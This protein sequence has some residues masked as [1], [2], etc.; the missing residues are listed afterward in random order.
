MWTSKKFNQECNMGKREDYIKDTLLG[1]ETP[2]DIPSTWNDLEKLLDKPNKKK[3]PFWFYLI[4]ALS[5]AGIALSIYWVN[6]EQSPIA[7]IAEAVTEEV[8]VNKVE[9][10]EAMNAEVLTTSVD[11]N[12]SKEVTGISLGQETAEVLLKNT[13]EEETKASQSLQEQ[14]YLTSSQ[15]KVAKTIKPI[16]KGGLNNANTLQINP[17]IETRKKSDVL[18]NGNIKKQETPASSS[19]HLISK[20]Q[21]LPRVISRLK[22]LNVFD[23]KNQRSPN[24]AAL[25]MPLEE[26]VVPLRSSSGL[27][28]TVE[29]G[30]TKHSLL[31]GEEE[32]TDSQSVLADVRLSNNKTLGEEAE[33]EFIAGYN[34]GMALSYSLKNGITF[35]TGLHYNSFH[36]KLVGEY[37][38]TE[39]LLDTIPTIVFNNSEGL[40]VA[41]FSVTE[42]IARSP[43][44]LTHY[45]KINTLHVPLNVGY[46]FRRKGF[47]LI[48]TLG[49]G[50]NMIASAQGR[51]FIN[52]NS[53]ADIS[54]E[55]PYKQNAL[56]YSMQAELGIHKRLSN[57]FNIYAGVKAGKYL[58]DIGTEAFSNSNLKYASLNL[59][60]SHN[61]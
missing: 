24:I 12:K 22:S 14:K 9:I 7:V 23:T 28:L 39:D 17:T 26:S 20:L 5:L 4:G 8:A 50:I 44:S 41:D 33:L 57:D 32:L 27:L 30:L 55:Q 34:L 19:V 51:Y 59:G 11:L 29:G 10:Q 36:S 37:N 45:N 18:S 31:F 15:M 53:V 42:S 43:R 48:S 47:Q 13:I 21:L 25:H 58:S 60:I 16:S 46:N 1:Y 6:M 38:Q 52:A 49:I 35:G 3:R 2:V 56:L 40:S 54:N 61:F